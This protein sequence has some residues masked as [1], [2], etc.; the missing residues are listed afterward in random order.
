MYDYSTAPSIIK[1]RLCQNELMRSN[2][3]HLQSHA[4]NC[5]EVKVLARNCKKCFLYQSQCSGTL[6]TLNTKNIVEL[7]GAV[8]ALHSFGKSHEYARS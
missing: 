3:F 6:N 8:S 1:S 4:S 7:V 2:N 5:K